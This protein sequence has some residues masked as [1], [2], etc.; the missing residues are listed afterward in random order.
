VSDRPCIGQLIHTYH[1]T[2]A[3][4]VA[5]MEVPA[6]ET[7]RYGII[8][9]EPSEDPLDH[10]RLHRVTALVEK[11]EPG[12][13]PS[14]LAVIGRYVLTP[15]I[16]DKLEQTQSGAGGEIQLT[17]AIS[18]LMEEQQVF[19]YEFEGTRY[20]AGTVMGWLKASV[21]I[22]LARVDL[23]TEFRAYLHGLQ[24]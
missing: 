21:E 17:D 23:G 9:S 11:P 8:A 16:F 15:K 4:V 18:A 10:G 7:S 12:E 2:H 20:D 19:G 22:A 6:E 24:L 3:S 5:V 1:Q 13:A 14:N